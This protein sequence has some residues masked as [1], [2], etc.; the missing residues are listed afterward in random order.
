MIVGWTHVVL[1]EDA[2]LRIIRK[3]TLVLQLVDAV[4]SIVAPAFAN[5]KLTLVH[6]ENHLR[7][8]QVVDKLDAVLVHLRL[9]W[10]A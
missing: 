9:H 8:S 10:N 1:E 5:F 7:W 2:I 6:S 3:V 4:K